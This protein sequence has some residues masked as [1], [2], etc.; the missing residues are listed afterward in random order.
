MAPPNQEPDNSGSDQERQGLHSSAESFRACLPLAGRLIGIDPGSKTFGLALSDLTRMIASPLEV[1]RR[2]KFKTDAERL[3]H[4]ADEHAIAGIVVGLPSN[5]DGT[6]GPR[7]QSVRAFVKNLQHLTSL[8][9]LLWD[10]RLSTVAAER[11]LLSADASRKRRDEVIDKVAA[12][13]ILQ[14]AMDR[15]RHK[16]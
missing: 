16:G 15:M 1:I 7:A 11:A 6:E 13:V 2:T 14:G 3:L 10:E 9:I 4:L 12:T 8:P 5:L